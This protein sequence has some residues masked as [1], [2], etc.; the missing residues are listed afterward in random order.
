M[1]VVAMEALLLL[2][3]VGLVLALG[4]WLVLG[5]SDSSEP[6]LSDLELDPIT[7]QL[8]WTLE[9]NGATLTEFEVLIEPGAL[10]EVT[11]VPSLDLEN[12]L[13]A[14]TSYTFTVT[15]RFEDADDVGAELV[16]NT[17]TPSALTTTGTPSVTTA[18]GASDAN[19]NIHLRLDVHL[20]EADGTG[21]RFMILRL[22]ADIGSSGITFF[23]TEVQSATELRLWT[24]AHAK[25]VSVFGG[26][27]HSMSEVSY[28]YQRFTTEPL[29]TI[30][31]ATI[32]VEV[33][34]GKIEDVPNDNFT[35]SVADTQ[36]Y[37][38]T[39]ETTSASTYPNSDSDPSP[40]PHL[41]LAQNQKEIGASILLA[42][43]AG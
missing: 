9:T 20:L 22:L 5:D 34:S 13:D 40:T 7:T 24:L 43:S 39:F 26:A 28:T 42:Q 38:F 3:L 23:V 4:T 17:R 14:D 2:V 8:T 15:A 30:E 32:A 1:A 35:L 6:V 31:L 36:G 10:R 11:H 16:T 18:T 37:S 41:S 12:Q 27:T 29:E 21:E 19:Q 25:N 33:L